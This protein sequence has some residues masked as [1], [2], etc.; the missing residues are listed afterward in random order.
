M[1]KLFIDKHDIFIKRFKEL[2]KY[3]SK[4]LECKFFKLGANIDY[5]LLEKNIMK[6]LIK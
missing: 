2:S 5:K 6:N 4:Y 1:N 3:N